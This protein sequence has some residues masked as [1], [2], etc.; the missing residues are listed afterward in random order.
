ML[1]HTQCI[2][3]RLGGS[4]PERSPGQKGDIP[5]A[6]K[7]QEPESLLN[8]AAGKMQRIWG[9]LVDCDAVRLNCFV[10]LSTC[11]STVWALSDIWIWINKDFYCYSC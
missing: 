2:Q 3:R 7:K 11:Q 1:P 10:C 8:S 4:Q 9:L 6:S 5:A